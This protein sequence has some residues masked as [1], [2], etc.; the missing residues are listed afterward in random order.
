VSSVI[1]GQGYERVVT[2]EA[3]PLDLD[4]A[5]LGSRMI[6]LGIDTLIQ[7]GVF[8]AIAFVLSALHVDDTIATVVVLVSVPVLFWGYFFVF[9]GLWHGRTPGK[10]A[11]R[12]R[13]TRTDGQ[14]M[15]GAQMFVRN[16]VRIVDFLPAYYAVRSI[17]I[18]VTKRSQRLGDLAAGTL[19]I[20]EAKA[21]AP[22]AIGSMPPPPPVDVGAPTTRIDVTAM[23]ETH[24]QLV[25]SYFERR[26][27]LDP[28]A[29]ARIARDIVVAIAPVA[30]SA[31]SLPDEAFLEAAA[32]AYRR[33]FAG[34]A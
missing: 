31:E 12:L 13:A 1:S 17:S 14:P 24:Y 30:R 6:A 26:A 28:A 18:V 15:S 23:R 25:R 4:V 8:F 22:L 7:I 27:T 10:R 34:G 29:R 5:G 33:R 3:V 21:I 2:P 19:V 11:Q 20:R 16:L 32:S 9:E